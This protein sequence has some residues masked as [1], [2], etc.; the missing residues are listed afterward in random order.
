MVCEI[1]SIYEGC[2]QGYEFLPG[3]EC[4]KGTI[5]T[6]G[7]SEGGCLFDI[8]QNLA[9]NGQHVYALYYFGKTCLPATLSQIE[10]NFFEKVVTYLRDTQVSLQPLTI[11]GASRGA[12]LA[13]LLASYYPTMV[14]HLVLFSPSAYAFQ[15]IQGKGTWL[16]QGKELPY[17]RFSR[18]STFNQLVSRIKKQPFIW[19][20]EFRKETAHN[21]NAL[22]AQID[23]ALYLGDMLLFVGKMDQVWHSLDMAELLLQ[24]VG[25][26]RCEVHIYEEAGHCFYPGYSLGGTFDGNAFA[27]QDSLRR[28]NEK[29]VEWHQ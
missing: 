29:I 6:F 8:A 1:K 3:K 24:K 11:V 12:E 23:P 22:V 7:G 5:L 18:K 4:V 21:K 14:S 2:V 15:G 26:K 9:E 19:A 13:L 10:L 20:N 27:Q 16:Y 28:M 17:I 25:G